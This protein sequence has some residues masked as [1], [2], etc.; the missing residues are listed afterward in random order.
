M[1]ST[2]VAQQSHTSL[3]SRATRTASVLQVALV[4][5]AV[6]HVATLMYHAAATVAFP[7]DLD[8]GEG[9]VLNDAL[10]LARGEP[11]YVDPQQFPMV[12]S[13]YP[14][15]FP[16]VWALWTP[17]AGPVFWPGRVQSLAALLAIV[18]VVVWNAR[19]GG[20]GRWAVLAAGA[21][22]VA[23]PFVYQWAPYA[24]VDLL[25]LAFGA[26]G[27]AV[28][29]RVRD[30]PGVVGSALLCLAA[31][32]TKQSYVAPIAAVGLALMVPSPR[33]GLA[34]GFL[35]AGPSLALGAALDA[36]TGGQFT[37][38]VVLGNAQNP[39]YGPRLVVYVLTFALLHLPLLLAAVWWSAR[40]WRGVPSPIAL[41]VP[42]TL[43]QS[44]TVGNQGSS[45]NYFLEPVVAM[46]LALPF[47]WRAIAP[48]PNGT[49]FAL[50]LAVMQLAMLLRWP[51]GVG[52][53][54]LEVAPHGRT[55]VAEDYAAAETIDRLVQAEPGD[56]LVEAA[57]FS[58]RNGRPVF[59]QPIDLRAEEYHGRWSDAPLLDTL[60]EGRFRLV[61][62]SYELMPF[63]AER[64]VRSTFLL[65]QEIRGANGLTYRVYRPPR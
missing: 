16:A 17:W 5:L 27:V 14:P 44:L 57:G 13:P 23:S 65:E 25:G 45:V 12:R 41:Y 19:S 39:W 15:L 42:L 31:L 51:N 50:V 8:Y 48:R 53:R 4:A 33:R 52:T 26:G 10:R 28:A 61:I 36:A 22:V 46:A 32:W 7:Y 55:P 3:P 40:S 47:A 35:V 58:L 2:A 60:R 63:G 20:A 11:I 9:Y 6:F 59:V 37:R 38:H 64:L 34:F 21:V 49:T 56:V 18:A 30:W 24:R 62:T 54:Y 29:H 43:M 1:R